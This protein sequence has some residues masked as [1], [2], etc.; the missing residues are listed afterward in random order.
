ML[1]KVIIIL[2]F[3]YN[4]MQ[5]VDIWMIDILKVLHFKSMTAIENDSLLFSSYLIVVDIKAQCL[6]VYDIAFTI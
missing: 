6:T 2:S 4:A 1:K 3:S 5:K